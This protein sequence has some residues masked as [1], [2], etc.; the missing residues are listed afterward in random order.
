MSDSQTITIQKDLLNKISSQMIKLKKQNINYRE[1]IKNMKI[2]MVESLRQ[3]Q[4]LEEKVE[5]FSDGFLS[6]TTKYTVKTL[7]RGSVDQAMVLNMRKDDD[8]ARKLDQALREKEREIEDILGNQRRQGLEIQ[9]LRASLQMKDEE[10][11]GLRQLSGQ[12]GDLDGFQELLDTQNCKVEDLNN[13]LNEKVEEINNLVKL[14][15]SKDKEIGHL[16]KL[17][18]ERNGKLNGLGEILEDKEDQID[19][20]KKA[21]T[22]KND[23]LDNLAEALSQKQEEIQQL[24][25]ELLEKEGE[26]ER[27]NQDLLKK[28]VN[29]ERMSTHVTEAGSEKINQSDIDKLKSL[30]IECE[31][32][33]IALKD[34]LKNIQELEANL[35]DKEDLCQKISLLLKEKEI[36]LENLKNENLERIEKLTNNL[37]MKEQEYM[38]LVQMIPNKEEN[39]E[40]RGR[41]SAVEQENEELREK[42]S[43][44]E[45]ENKTFLGLLK[46][47]DEKINKLQNAIQENTEREEVD[48]KDKNTVQELLDKI[49]KKNTKI[50]NLEKEIE[51]VKTEYSNIIE[52]LRDE[53]DKITNRMKKDNQILRKEITSLLDQK[54]ELR[55]SLHEKLQDSDK[56]REQIELLEGDYNSKVDEK[57]S[58]F[59]DYVNKTKIKLIKKIKSLL[60]VIE[61]LREELEEVKAGINNTNE[62][63][64]LESI[65]AIESLV[66]EMKKQSS[67]RDTRPINLMKNPSEKSIGEHFENKSKALTPFGNVNSE[68]LIERHEMMDYQSLNSLPN[69]EE[70]ISHLQT[71]LFEQ[72]EANRK[73]LEMNYR[74]EDLSVTTEQQNINDPDELDREVQE[75]R[76]LRDRLK[77]ETFGMQSDLEELEEEKE[78]GLLEIEEHEAHLSDLKEHIQELDHHRRDLEDEIER[79]N[80]NKTDNDEV[81]V[82]KSQLDETQ[83]I[84][85]KLS[86][87]QEKPEDKEDIS[88]FEDRRFSTNSTTALKEL[89]EYQPDLPRE[90]D[91]S[92]IIINIEGESIQMIVNLINN[93]LE[94]IKE[95]C[96]IVYREYDA[97]LEM[98][99]KL[100]EYGKSNP[101]IKAEL[102]EIL[103]GENSNQNLYKS[104]LSGTQF[105]SLL[106]NLIVKALC[107]MANVVNE[108][109]MKRRKM[110]LSQ[111]EE[112]E[113]IYDKYVE[114][115]ET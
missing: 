43:A 27:L 8:L 95:R 13:N 22:S 76:R 98:L 81:K 93:F 24:C 82:L 105:V 11:E 6:T 52:R 38:N 87:M 65:E 64:Y 58:I 30:E 114:E 51:D 21:L 5:E 67:Q 16:S 79:I 34:A 89:L 9:K 96:A 113:K 44:V 62:K 78:K 102:D 92:K 106:K 103:H 107:E 49:Q 40:L 75:L 83:K 17:V 100:S 23:K 31:T 68:R 39:E 94:F 69:N 112:I 84:I 18:D 63:G 28:T 3:S 54:E 14:L 33:D 48:E 88:S 115:R 57:A 101:E 59:K 26:I 99:I 32:K 2:F 97:Y 37:K 111:R 80:S 25:K 110:L 73:L 61:D 109:I 19:Y 77:H 4:S 53:R 42:L 86:K 91:N 72:K 1:K 15:A 35:D 36:D 90:A 66:E 46:E 74:S 104:L 12:G 29:E 50:D 20:L 70:K 71:L 7:Q 10:I 56:F 55:N 41:L 47:K 108:R 60:N 85:E 45:Q